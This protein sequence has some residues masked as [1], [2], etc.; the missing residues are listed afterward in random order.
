MP[1]Y[2]TNNRTP[3][4]VGVFFFFQAEDGIRYYKVTGSDVCSS[5]PDGPDFALALLIE[6]TPRHSLAGLGVE[7]RGNLEAAVV[8]YARARRGLDPDGPDFARAVVTAEERPVGK[9]GRSRW[10]PDH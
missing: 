5:D 10:S 7:P 1:K 3:E 6:G 9:E 2:R 8:L 4:I